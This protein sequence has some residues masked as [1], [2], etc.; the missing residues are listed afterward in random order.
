MDITEVTTQPLSTLVADFF[1][2]GD[3]GIVDRDEERCLKGR[4]CSACGDP[5]RGGHSYWG[6]RV[7]AL[8]DLI[9][10]AYHRPDPPDRGPLL[11]AAVASQKLAVVIFFCT[12]GEVL[13]DH[14]LVECMLA[15]QIPPQVRERLLEDSLSAR[16]RV[17][18]LFPTLTGTT[19]RKAVSSL[20]Q[21]S[22]LGYSATVVFYLGVMEHRNTL[23]HSGSV[24]AVRPEVPEECLRRI[25]PLLNLFG[26]LH[27]TFVHP[28]YVQTDRRYDNASE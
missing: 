22:S 8:I 11:N 21:G 15:L 20:D 5:S 3:C 9:Q 26:V 19:W 24:W 27:N 10:E 23:L 28:T 13:L 1:V 25:P 2:C 18:R 16:Q 4:P 12:L 6:I 17:D 14:F 7:D